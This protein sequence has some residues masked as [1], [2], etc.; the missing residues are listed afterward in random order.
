MKKILIF[1][2]A[3]ML[4]GLLITLFGSDFTY[5]GAKKCKMCH[6]KKEGLNQYHV[7]EESKHP[8][9][10]EA[11][12]SESA[13]K[14][15]K[16]RKL[17]LPPTESEQCL[18]CH[19]PLFEKAAE[20]NAEGVTCEYCHGAGSDYKKLSIMKDKEGAAKNG[21]IVYQS[22]NDIQKMC[23]ICHGQEGFDFHPY[24]DKIKHPR[25]IKN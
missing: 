10:F 4:F 12:K 7:W 15:A 9:A 23:L 1:T 13:L 8:H 20:L 19:A 24:W 22:E 11:L 5:V 18:K 16:E 25:K 21:L 2:I 17:D 14:T 3:L 6:N